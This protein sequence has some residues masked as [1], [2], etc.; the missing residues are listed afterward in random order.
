MGESGDSLAASSTLSQTLDPRGSSSDLIVLTPDLPL[1]P[2]LASTSWEGDRKCT[3]NYS[4][5]GKVGGRFP[6]HWLQAVATASD[7]ER[8]RGT[9]K[10][11]RD[12]LP[13]PPEPHLEQDPG[14]RGPLS[15]R[16]R[17]GGL[18]GGLGT[19]IVL[20]ILIVSRSP[21]CCWALVF[22]TRPHILVNMN[23]GR[24]RREAKGGSHSTEWDLPTRAELSLVC[25]LLLRSPPLFTK[26]PPS[27]TPLPPPVGT[28]K[29]HTEPQ[30]KSL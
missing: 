25:H 26:C 19:D 6:A 17:E 8:V 9:A 18:G 16:P 14:P 15:G 20:P 29:R 24:Q 12:Q 23:S 13:T 30:V 11:R 3:S 1:T 21:S 27:T 2:H 5:G 7:P 10:P 28:Q 22:S 4:L